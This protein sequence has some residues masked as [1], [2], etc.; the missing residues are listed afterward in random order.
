MNIQHDKYE[1]RDADTQAED[2]DKGRNFITP[3]YP[4]GN[5]EKTSN[6]KVGV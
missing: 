4:Q 1:R 2:I 5:G 6:H 3:K